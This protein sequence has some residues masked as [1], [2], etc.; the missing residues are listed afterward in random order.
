MFIVGGI[1]VTPVRSM[2]VRA[3]HEHLP[4]KLLMLYLNRLP[5]DTAFLDELI[6][7]QKQ[8]A[9]FRFVPIMTAAEAAENWS[10][11]KDRLTPELLNKY[12]SET[13]S[14]IYYLV[15][16]PGMVNAVH[17][18]LNQTGVD[19]DDIRLED[20]GGYLTGNAN[21]R[22]VCFRS[23]AFTIRRRKAMANAIWSNG[24]GRVA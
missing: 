6:G 9:N 22:G 16:P 3:A 17:E 21:M 24:S 7:L 2:L 12:I 1:G 11:E 13:T 4:H 19:D 18:L 8:N 14:P 20:F 5:Q 23:N 15:G 10:G